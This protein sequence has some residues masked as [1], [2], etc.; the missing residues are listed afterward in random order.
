MG[1]RMIETR[2]GGP[3]SASEEVEREGKTARAALHTKSLLLRNITRLY[4]PCRLRGQ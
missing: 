4:Q 2:R 3:G 1:A